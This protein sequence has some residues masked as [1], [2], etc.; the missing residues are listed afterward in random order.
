MFKCNFFKIPFKV[1]TT[2]LFF[3]FIAE[4]FCQVQLHK[5]FYTKPASQFEEALLMGNG[6]IGATIYGGV[7]EER[8]SLNEATLWSGGPFD[9][10]MNPKAKDYLQPVREALFDEN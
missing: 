7:K 4:C 5:L 2:F 3:F 9:P 1:L 6:R 8:I 10:S